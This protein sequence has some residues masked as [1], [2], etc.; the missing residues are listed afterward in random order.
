MS[1]RSPVCVA[2]CLAALFDPVQLCEADERVDDATTV[3][4]REKFHRQLDD[5]IASITRRIRQS[6]KEVNLYSQRGDKNFFRARFAD[7]VRDYDSM[8]ELDPDLEASHWRRGIALFYAGRYEDAARQFEIYHTFDNIDR[9]NG[10]WRYLSQMKG[11]GRE[12]AR[13]GLLKYEKDDREPFPHVYRLFAGELTAQEVLTRSIP[14]GIPT[15]ERHKREFYA[16]LYVGLDLYVNDQAAGAL[17][18]LREAVR[19]PWGARAGG[20]PGYM[21]HV[22]RVHH[23]LLRDAPPK[24]EGSEKKKE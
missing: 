19:N 2:I 9:E 15:D 23:D 18:H 7:A 1:A 16:R 11:A 22:A 13:Q 20:G 5:E 4:W 3:E 14:A 17:P 12:K 8:V 24:A 10:I 6:P 21:W